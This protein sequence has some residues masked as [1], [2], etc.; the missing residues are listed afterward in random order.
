MEDDKCSVLRCLSGER[1]E[2]CTQVPFHQPGL[3]LGGNLERRAQSCQPIRLLRPY[4]RVQPVDLA[5]DREVHWVKVESRP[6]DDA[7][8]PCWDRRRGID[9]A[10]KD[11]RRRTRCLETKNSPAIIV[12][13]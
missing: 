13:V 2:V 5:G 4:Q 3:L 7:R 6:P 11:G 9:R 1:R 10:G 12:T 8:W